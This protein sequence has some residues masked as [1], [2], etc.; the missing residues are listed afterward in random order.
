MTAFV[1]Y[2]YQ[3]IILNYNFFLLYRCK[4][5]YL[6]CFPAIIGIYYNHNHPIHK[7][8]TEVSPSHLEEGSDNSLPL[9]NSSNES[10]QIVELHLED[11][12]SGECFNHELIKTDIAPL[13]IRDPDLQDLEEMFKEFV[14]NVRRCYDSY[15]IEFHFAISKAKENYKRLTTDISLL[16]CLMEF[17]KQGE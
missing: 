16:N 17:G 1:Y 14:H 13:I 6:P 7:T 8:P 3:N 9:S 15:P 5:P 2:R 12:K 4:D 10:H 11:D